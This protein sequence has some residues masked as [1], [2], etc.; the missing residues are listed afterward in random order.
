MNTTVGLLIIGALVAVLFWQKTAAEEPKPGYAETVT[1]NERP[2]YE[3]P[4]TYTSSPWRI[5]AY[6]YGS[7]YEYRRFHSPIVSPRC[8]VPSVIPRISMS[9][10]IRGGGRH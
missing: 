5:P 6:S 8:G 2:A 3:Y 4:T 1:I 7:T 10:P 9:H